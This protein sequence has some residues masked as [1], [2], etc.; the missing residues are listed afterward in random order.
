MSC[1]FG[2]LSCVLT[3]L[4][5]LQGYWILLVMISVCNYK[6]DWYFPSSKRHHVGP[7][8]PWAAKRN[9]NCF[10]SFGRNKGRGLH[11]CRILPMERSR[12]NY[13]HTRPT[14][15]PKSLVPLLNDLKKS[16]SIYIYKFQM[17]SN[18]VKLRHLGLLWAAVIWNRL[19]NAALD[20]QGME[21]RA[22]VDDIQSNADVR[23]CLTGRNEILH[24][25]GNCM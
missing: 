24:L 14:S 13:S 21:D 18:M 15:R 19:V 22:V 10:V 20:L 25:Y 2:S 3:C 17:W 11:M 9:S 1:D 6:S 12:Y 5:V 16:T 8:E 7:C 23:Q 4:P